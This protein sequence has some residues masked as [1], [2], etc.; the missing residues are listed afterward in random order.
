MYSKCLSEFVYYFGNT[1]N[2][3]SDKYTSLIKY[4]SAAIIY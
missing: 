2:S 3:I 1:V 4:V